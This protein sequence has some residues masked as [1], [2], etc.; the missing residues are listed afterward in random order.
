MVVLFVGIG[1]ASIA[2][3]DRKFRIES[4]GL[5]VIGDGAVEI[6]LV[7]VGDPAVVIRAC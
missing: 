7:T 5:G 6:A 4:D 1:K 2:V 3:G